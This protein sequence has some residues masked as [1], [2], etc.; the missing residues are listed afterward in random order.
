MEMDENTDLL[1]E[2][3]LEK[4]ECFCLAVTGDFRKQNLIT[5]VF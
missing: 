1:L 5:F 2:A 4:V 3:G